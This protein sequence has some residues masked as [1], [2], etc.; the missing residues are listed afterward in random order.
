MA[1]RFVPHFDHAL[2]GDLATLYHAVPPKWLTPGKRKFH[3]RGR[4]L[5]GVLNNSARPLTIW[6]SV[7]KN[8]PRVEEVAVLAE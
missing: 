5:S 6:N 1:L 2:R 3:V 7:D 8:F 4:V